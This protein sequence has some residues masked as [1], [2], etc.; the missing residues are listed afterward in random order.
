MQATQFAQVASFERVSPA[1]VERARKLQSAI[2]CDVVGR[3]G[4]LHGRIQALSP[5]MKVVGPAFPVEVRPG[6]NLMFHVALAL[7][8]P[9]DVVIVDGKDY[10]SSALLGELMATQAA[11]AQLAGLV[12][13]GAARDTEVLSAGALPVFASGRNPAGPT[14]GLGG[15]VGVDISIG[16][17]AV[18][19]G[20][21]VIGDCDGVVVIPR[22]QVDAA[23]DAGEA[24][25]RAEAQRL[26]E[27]KEG[28]LVSSW[29]NA[30]LR[31]AG[32]IAADETLT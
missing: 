16:G 15:T 8:R 30:A 23:L 9:G 14:K 18:R 21:L 26:Q 4:A 28:M 6:D 2:L 19:A 20:D 12:V 1:Q 10:Q 29:L 25:V 32:V 7:A 5:T 3:R 13:D 11:A 24:K 27:I 31:S 22:E 17:V